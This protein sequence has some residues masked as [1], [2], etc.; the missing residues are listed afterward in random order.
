MKSDSNFAAVLAH[1]EQEPFDVG[2]GPTYARTLIS[3]GSPEFSAVFRES[4]NTKR[5]TFFMVSFPLLVTILVSV[6]LA[7]M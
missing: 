7:A 6:I 4:R 3:P 1:E 2:M 5:I